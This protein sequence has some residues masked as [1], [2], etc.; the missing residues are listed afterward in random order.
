MRFARE[1]WVPTAVVAILALLVTAAFG[2]PV[3]VVPA[4]GALAVLLFFRD[5]VRLPL[6]APGDLLAPA[7]G[8]V[9]SVAANRPHA[10]CAEARR[11]VSIFMSPLDVH[12]NR[13]PVTGVVEKREYRRGSFGAAYKGDASE[14]NE[15]NALL[16]RSDAGYPLVVVQI[17]GWLARRI[18]CDIGEGDRVMRG[19]RFGLIMF[20][21]R[22]DVYLPDAVTVCV[23]PGQPVPAGNTVFASPAAGGGPVSPESARAPPSGPGA[24]A[25]AV[26]PDERD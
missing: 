7:D 12:V 8:R 24:G 18:V 20:G 13:S 25:G 10:L 26:L 6:G 4:I 3:G 2:W 1:G 21:S 23:T 14:A 11:R 19:A 22:V 5:P 15:A 9:I 17:A 16:V